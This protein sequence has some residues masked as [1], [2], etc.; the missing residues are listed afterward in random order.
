MAANRYGVLR[1]GCFAA[2]L[3]PFAAVAGDADDDTIRIVATDAGFEAP[4]E[5][6]AGLRHL[7]FANRGTRIH[8]AMLVRLPDGMDAQGYVAAVRGGSLFPEGARDYSGPG[9]TSPGQSSELWLT[10]DPGRY[11]LIC[12]NDDD[13]TTVP[14]HPF[15][16][17]AGKVPDA[18]PPAADV[19]VRMRDFRF[20]LEG[21]PKAGAQVFRID[22]AGPSMHEIDMFRLEPGRTLDDLKRWRK[23]TAATAAPVVALGGALDSHDIGHRVWIRL[24]LEPGRHALHCEMPIA[25]AAQAGSDFATHADAG[26]ATEFE[27]R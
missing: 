9:L 25:M 22:N 2:M 7:H 27:V 23:D 3:A 24:T 18:V 12:W 13:S 17:V 26:M 19:V 14:V 6:P 15:R 4:A 11:I 16:A 10:I 1:A 5:V 21:T 20:E 8:E